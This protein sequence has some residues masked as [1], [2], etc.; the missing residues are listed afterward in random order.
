MYFPGA[1][2]QLSITPSGIID[3]TDNSRLTITCSYSGSTPYNLVSWYK[4]GST[5]Y[6]RWTSD[7][8]P[9]SGVADPNVVQ[10]TCTNNGKDFALTF[11]EVKRNQDGQKWS[12]KVNTNPETLS[13]N[14]TIK[15]KGRFIF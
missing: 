8:T 5:V 4:D 11:I 14:V 6:T 7:C 9:F 13:A 10:F 1:K 2:G 3:V 15:I 12:C